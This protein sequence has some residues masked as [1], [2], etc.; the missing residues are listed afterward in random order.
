MTNISPPLI[1]DLLFFILELVI[2]MS[3]LYAAWVNLMQHQ[4]SKVGFDAFILLFL[5]H[6]KRGMIQE[7]QRLVKRVGVMALLVGI[8]GA[9]EAV[10]IFIQK[11]PPY[12][13]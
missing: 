4:T 2:T 1:C 8:G 6:T 11:I 12:F 9:T 5:N 13:Q 3:S 7:N 10:S